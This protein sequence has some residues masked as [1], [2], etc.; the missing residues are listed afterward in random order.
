MA[1]KE[2]EFHKFV[3]TLS[4]T[5]DQIPCFSNDASVHDQDWLR[6]LIITGFRGTEMPPEL[7]A[8]INDFQNA[9]WKEPTSSGQAPRRG[10]DQV[11][12]A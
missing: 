4:E 8:R 7:P 1:K 9:T 10:A 2:E 5:F 3:D 6:P 12:L 11:E